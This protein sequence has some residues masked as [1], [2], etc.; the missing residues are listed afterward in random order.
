MRVPKQCIIALVVI[1]C[2]GGMY[3]QVDALKLVTYEENGESRL[4]A[5]LGETVVDLNRAY[6]RLLQQRG[7]PP[8]RALADV[9]VPP[10]MLG[11][12]RGKNSAMEAANEA[13]LFAQHHPPAELQAAG[14]VTALTAVR[15]RA[16][17]PQPTKITGIGLNYRAHAEEMKTQVPTVPLLFGAYPSAVIGP[18]DAIMI[19]KGA[20]QVDYETELG[21]VIGKRGK[22]V[23]RENW[24]LMVPKC[25]DER[26]RIVVQRQTVFAICSAD[27]SPFVVGVQ[28]TTRITRTCDSAQS[29]WWFTGN[30]KGR[31][32]RSGKGV[33]QGFGVLEI[34]RV[35]AFSEPAINL[36]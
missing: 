9:L 28:D 3:A 32:N 8:A 6:A 2:V 30:A 17:L 10:D 25:A 26:Q 12:L 33:E 4:G 20:T 14:S 27:V 31:G 36:L 11:F 29:L 7:Q 34:R 21:I 19:P 22:H 5:L 13:V 18:T 1:L 35:K 23:P 16:P 15:L 24:Y